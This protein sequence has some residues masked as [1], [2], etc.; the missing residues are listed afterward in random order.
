MAGLFE[1]IYGRF[2]EDP[3]FR[4]DVL[5]HLVR[6]LQESTGKLAHPATFTHHMLTVKAQGSGSQDHGFIP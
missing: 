2:C 4:E 3:N 5:V 6:K 1:Q